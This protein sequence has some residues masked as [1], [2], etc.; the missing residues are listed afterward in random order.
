MSKKL[1]LIDA[2]EFFGYSVG[3]FASSLDV[4]GPF[5]GEMTPEDEVDEAAQ[6]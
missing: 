4:H 1:T 6:H 2:I 5:I 3:S